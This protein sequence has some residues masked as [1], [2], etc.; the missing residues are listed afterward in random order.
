M[1]SVALV[2]M[3]KKKRGRGG[4]RDVPILGKLFDEWLGFRDEVV[5]C[6]RTGL[7][8]SWFDIPRFFI[9]II[10][11]KWLCFALNE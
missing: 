7:F 8:D 10:L 4:R 2:P 1:E 11:T 3:K 5:G 9:I 6:A